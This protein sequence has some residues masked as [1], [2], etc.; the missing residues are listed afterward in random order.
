ML[1]IADKFSVSEINPP[2]AFPNEA[3]LLC[4]KLGAAKSKPIVLAVIYN[5]PHVNSIAF[6]AALSMLLQHLS[7]LGSEIVILGDFNIDLLKD[8]PLP[9]NLI[10]TTREFGLYQVLNGATRTATTTV[11]SSSTLIDHIYVNEPSLYNSTGHFPAFGSDHDLIFTVRKGLKA[12]FQP[13]TF[14]YRS[15]RSIDWSSLM[16]DLDFPSQPNLESFNKKV[17]EVINK[18]APLKTKTIKGRQNPWFNLSILD[19]C[20]ERDK[21]KKRFNKTNGPIFLKKYK[22]LRNQVNVTS[23]R[24]KRKFFGTNSM[25]TA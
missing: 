6:M 8:S 21:A 10:Q 19:L 22:T 16:E 18:H 23:R 7:I 14:T 4:V 25:R 15:L 9:R 12:K 2:T 24:T 17:L 3:E 11:S 20:I 5:P 13:I 1:Y